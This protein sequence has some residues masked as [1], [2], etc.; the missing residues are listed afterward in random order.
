MQHRIDLVLIL[1][2]LLGEGGGVGVIGN[3]FLHALELLFLRAGVQR[4][5]VL[6]DELVDLASV[7]VE[8]VEGAC[9]GFENVALRIGALGGAG[10][11]A[12]VT[13]LFR[14]HSVQA[15]E[16]A[17]PNDRGAGQRRGKIGL[18]GRSLPGCRRMRVHGIHVFG[19]TGYAGLCRR[20]G[21]QAQQCCQRECAQWSH[22]IHPFLYTQKKHFGFA[23]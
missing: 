18:C 19:G 22:A 15:I 5:P 12:D 14:L 16:H 3:G 10:N 23:A 6:G 8:H 11:A 9:V 2:L 20:T 7:D 1:T 4:Y 21:A 13:L 17:L